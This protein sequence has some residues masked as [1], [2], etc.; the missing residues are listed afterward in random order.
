[1]NESTVICNSRAQVDSAILQVKSIL[2]RQ[3]FETAT[4]AHQKYK[5]EVSPQIGEQRTLTQNRCIHKYCDMLAL[6]LN[7]AGYD[8]II[9]SP[10]LSEP[11]TVPW[12]KET[13]KQDIWH[14]V[15]MALTQK[16]SSTELKTKEVNIIYEAISRRMAEAFGVSTPFPTQFTQ[17]DI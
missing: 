17:G 6:D 7:A 11:L 15:Q 10:V 14:R 8:R 16:E 1:M 2:A 12:V 3:S 4:G 5:I 9:S 13:V